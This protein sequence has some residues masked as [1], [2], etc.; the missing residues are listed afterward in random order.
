M[1]GLGAMDPASL[2]GV[3]LRGL[4]FETP[5]RRVVR[6]AAERLADPSCARVLTSFHDAEGR[7]LAARLEAL[8]LDAPS[9]ARMVLFYDGSSEGLCRRPR[10]YAFTVPGSRLVRVCP[11]LGWAALVDPPLAEAVVIHEVLHTLGLPENP[12][13]SEQITTAVTRHC[14]L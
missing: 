6:S 5:V 12:P 13:T 7:P 11:E 2:D 14:G 9:Y 4:W 10:I 8:A 1:L 3:R